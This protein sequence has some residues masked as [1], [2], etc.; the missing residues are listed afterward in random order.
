M[1]GSNYIIFSFLP[2]MAE[3]APGIDLRVNK[4]A[5][6]IIDAI[7]PDTDKDLSSR[8]STEA[9]I[10]DDKPEEELFPVKDS[11]GQYVDTFGWDFAEEPA[12]WGIRAVTDIQRD[13][14]G[15]ITDVTQYF[16]DDPGAGTA[17]MSFH[18]D[19]M[20]RFTEVHLDLQNSELQDLYGFPAAADWTFTY[21]EDG[22]EI[23]NWLME[24]HWLSRHGKRY[25]DAEGNELEGC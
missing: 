14:R 9:E 12:R 3:G 18:Y 6:E 22:S 13:E 20:N 19:E 5:K 1:E 23:C 8:E 11:L 7:W 2:H 17:H 25:F 10:M 21:E 4:E 15:N 24:T 16:P